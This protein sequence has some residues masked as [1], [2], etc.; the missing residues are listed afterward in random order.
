MS[1]SISESY[2]CVYRKLQYFPLK[3]NGVEVLYEVALK[4]KHST[5]VNVLGYFPL[6]DKSDINIRTFTQ[7]L[8]FSIFFRV[9]WFDFRGKHSTFLLHYIPHRYFTVTQI[10]RWITVKTKEI[11]C[12]ITLISLWQEP[13]TLHKTTS[14][15]GFVENTFTHILLL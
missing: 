3:W 6:L 2:S 10:N 7:E 9:L 15:F 5:W 1:C 8:Y 12:I 13:I 14:T 4:R 11:W